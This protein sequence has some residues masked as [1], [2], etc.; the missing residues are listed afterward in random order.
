M[1]CV[2]DEAIRRAKDGLARPG[3]PLRINAA[4]DSD[5]A[6]IAALCEDIAVPKDQQARCEAIAQTPSGHQHD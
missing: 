2:T 3:W 6:A 1:N 5:A 4:C